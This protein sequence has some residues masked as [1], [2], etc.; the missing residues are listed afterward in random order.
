MALKY[1][2]S[3][4][5]VLTL[6]QR[7]G[8]GNYNPTGQTATSTGAGSFTVNGVPST[9]VNCF[10]VGVQDGC[11]GTELRSAG[12]CSI[13]VSVSAGDKQNTVTWPAY[14]GTDPT[15]IYRINRDGSP[16]GSRTSSAPLVDAAN[17]QC[18]VKY[19]YDVSLKLDNNYGTMIYSAPVCVVGVNNEPPKPPTKAFVS[20]E[21]DGV[22]LQASLPATVP[23]AY[24]LLV[25]RADGP[26]G[27]F[28]PIGQ[29]STDRSYTDKTANSAV[30]SYCYRTAIQN[31]CGIISD[32]TSPACTVHLTTPDNNALTWTAFSP[33]SGS[34]AA[35]YQVIKVD[36]T[37]GLSDKIDVGGNT[38]WEP[39][40]NQNRYPN[41]HV[42]DCGL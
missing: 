13:P 22:K 27:P 10:Q 24:T 8:S 32:Y 41:L 19:C 15:R 16:V 26:G 12:V 18:G 25:T 9:N 3:V 29:V 20:V 2:S 34:A 36:P 4:G 30:Q 11:G 37:T 7:D 35:G 42:P 33:F 31:N 39:N 21:A 5:A 6:Y 28:L 1:N 38:R 14:P 40:P 17:I 23:T